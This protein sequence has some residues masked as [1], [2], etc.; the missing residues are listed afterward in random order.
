MVEGAL[1]ARYQET[2]VTV[3]NSGIQMRYGPAE[4]SYE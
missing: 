1:A 2:V 4:Q 3:A